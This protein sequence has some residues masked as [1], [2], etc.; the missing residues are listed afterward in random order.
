MSTTRPPIAVTMGDP[1]G[2]G[3]EITLKLLADPS[4]VRTA[5]D[6]AVLLVKAKVQQE[7]RQD[8]V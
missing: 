1:V 5:F 8:G 3:P 7:G 6:Q 2:I 4:S